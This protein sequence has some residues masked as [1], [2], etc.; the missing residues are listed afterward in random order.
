MPPKAKSTYYDSNWEKEFN[1]LVP[2]STSNKHGHCKL[3]KKDIN[4]S[5]MGK[6]AITSH[7]KSSAHEKH[8]KSVS[9]T[10]DLSEM[11]AMKETTN[12]SLFCETNT[13]LSKR[14]EALWLFNMVM[15]H[16]TFRS[17]SNS[18]ICFQIAL[19]PRTFP[20]AMIKLAI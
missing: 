19:L 3:C 11:F 8:V 18:A 17:A 13:D 2:L 6:V 5:N 7:A 4:L 14:A 16:Q 20:W 15:E 1:W 12:K 9:N 10:I